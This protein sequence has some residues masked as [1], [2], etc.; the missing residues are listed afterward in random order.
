[1]KKISPFILRRLSTPNS[2]EG[3]RP[4]STRMFNDSRS[5][6]VLGETTIGSGLLRR[7]V[8]TNPPIRIPPTKNRFQAYRFQS[9]LKNGIF[10]GTQ[11]AQMCV[12]EEEILRCLLPSN[13]KAGTASPITAPATYQGQGW[14]IISSIVFS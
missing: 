9:Y 3:I 10:A 14:R 11:A 8:A 13:S 5:L 6:A 12:S 1:M 4:W 7:G 2:D